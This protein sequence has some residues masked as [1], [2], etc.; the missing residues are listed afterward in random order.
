M[1]P[2]DLYSRLLRQHLFVSLFRACAHSLAGENASRIAS[3]QA[4]ERS[5]AERLEE[6]REEWRR[7]RQTLITE[8]LL[9]VITGF[10]MLR[11]D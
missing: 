11:E 7:T 4:A 8:E 6:F 5:I 10:E 1:K 2:S 3:M 9:D